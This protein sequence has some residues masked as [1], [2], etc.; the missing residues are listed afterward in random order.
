[1]FISQN[2]FLQIYLLVKKY[3]VK[4]NLH[5]SNALNIGSGLSISVKELNETTSSNCT[6]LEVDESNDL[7]GCQVLKDAHEKKKDI[8]IISF[9]LV[10]RECLNL[11]SFANTYIMYS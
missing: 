3:F 5:D 11:E 6:G 9:V 2:L 4:L 10:L 8:S 1:M 7:R